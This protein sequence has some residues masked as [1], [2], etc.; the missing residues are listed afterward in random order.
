MILK[1]IK[2]IESLLK[3]IDCNKLTDMELYRVD[4]SI[5]NMEELYNSLIKRL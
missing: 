4:E 5:L 2:K 1:K 3:E